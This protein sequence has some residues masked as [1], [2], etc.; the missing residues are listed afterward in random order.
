MMLQAILSSCCACRRKP[1]KQVSV[2]TI[3][4]LSRLGAAFFNMNAVMSATVFG[5]ALVD[6]VVG[7]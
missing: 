6:R 1:S 7:H 3:S 5:F 4:D 2:S